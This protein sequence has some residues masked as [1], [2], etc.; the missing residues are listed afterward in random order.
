MTVC[1]KCGVPRDEGEFKFL[2]PRKDGSRSRDKT[3]RPCRNRDSRSYYH[4]DPD[5]AWRYKLWK[6]YKI[7]PER[8]QEILDAQGGACAVCGLESER[9]DVDHDHS[10]CEGPNSCGECVR[11]LLCRRCNLRVGMFESGE[12]EAIQ[13]Y[14]G[15][16]SINPV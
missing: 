16:A 9:L 7:T 8:Y 10:C 11:G 3:C 5:R 1:V 12:V 4:S 13:M 6:K 2:M 15:R 14:L